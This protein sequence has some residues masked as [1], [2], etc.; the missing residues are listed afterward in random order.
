MPKMLTYTCITCG[1]D[2]RKGNTM[3]KYCSNVCCGKAKFKRTIER[4]K[5]GNVRERCTLRK[6]LAELNGY[7]CAECG[8]SD[9]NNKPLTLQVDHKNGKANDNSLDNL[10]LL[11]PNCH[12]QTPFFGGANKGQGRRALGLPLN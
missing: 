12:A 4:A 9:Y 2:V 1:K 5:K 10:Q 8:I 7:S 6:V 3:G 11:C